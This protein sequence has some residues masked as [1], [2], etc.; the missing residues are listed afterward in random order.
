VAAARPRHVIRERPDQRTAAI[1]KGTALELS[2]V[3]KSFGSFEAVGGVSFAVEAGELL[4]VV[5][6]NGAG[7]TSLIRCIADGRERSSG[8]VTICGQAAGDLPPHR[9]VAMGVG[10]KFQAANVFDSLTVAESLQLAGWKGRLPSLWR[11]SSAVTL[12][13]AA[14]HVMQT[15]GLQELL[16]TKVMNLGHGQKQALE[17]AMVLCL[18]PTVLL[19]DE[20][21]AGL[22]REER[23]A[24]AD[25]LTHLVS[26]GDMCIV[27]IEHDFEFVKQISTRMIVLHEGKLLLDGTVQEVSES[28]AVKSV[29]LGHTVN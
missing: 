10:R 3:R 7:K 13:G 16:D 24:I 26:E 11:K 1:D 29:Y 2:G 28:D 17:L 12:P 19:L 20:P 5:G 25:V 15:T 23:Y 22:T 14:L 18:E 27:L 9:L 8:D 21:T 4:S 6:P